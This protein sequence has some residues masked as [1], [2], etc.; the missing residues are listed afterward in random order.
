[1]CHFDKFKTQDL[2]LLH[3]CEWPAGDTGVWP[4]T[5]HCTPKEADIT[6]EEQPLMD[7]MLI[8]FQIR[9]VIKYQKHLLEYRLYNSDYRN[10]FSFYFWIVMASLFIY[11][12]SIIEQQFKPFF[13][14]LKDLGFYFIVISFLSLNYIF[15]NC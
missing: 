6:S 14:H 5:D 9:Q 13:K 2:S 1:M 3:P 10:V 8:N 15:L 7:P 12:F 11:L 4:P